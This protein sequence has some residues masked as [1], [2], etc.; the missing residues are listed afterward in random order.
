MIYADL[1]HPDT[2]APL[3]DHPIW[4]KAIDW[5]KEM[6]PDIKAGIYEIQG[7]DM[8]VN[9]HG[10]DPLPRDKCRYESHQKY[11]DLQYCIRGGEL[12]D[13]CLRS[14]MEPDGHYDYEKD[15]QYYKSNPADSVLHMIPGRFAVFYPSDTHRP[16]I[17]DGIETAVYKLVIKISRHLIDI[18]SKK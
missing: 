17:E 1:H 13:W 10:Y 2:Y 3:L 4:C 6:S 14:N 9:V 8:F 15:L 7:K 18:Q 11:V 12:I 5:L 16:K